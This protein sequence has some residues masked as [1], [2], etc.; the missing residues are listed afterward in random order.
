MRAFVQL[1]R[2]CDIVLSV[3]FPRFLS[4]TDH[5]HYS[6]AETF[7]KLQLDRNVEIIST[8][9]DAASVGECVFYF[10]KK[11]LYV[12]SFVF[13]NV[14]SNFICNFAHT[15]LVILLRPG[16]LLLKKKDLIYLIL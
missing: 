4:E 6:S 5:D 15:C 3:R 12:G 1:I 2:G 8:S 14:G 11:F 9:A 7:R 10:L 16:F 13:D